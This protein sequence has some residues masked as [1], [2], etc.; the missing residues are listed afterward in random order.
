MP[1]PIGHALVGLAIAWSAESIRRV[2]LGTPALS[3]LAVTCAALATAPDLDFIYPPVHRMMSHSVTAVAAVVVLM[4]VVARRAYPHAPGLFALVSALA[5]ASHLALDWMGTDTNL[6]RGIQLWWPFSDGWFISSLEV[7]RVTRL[8]G[9]FTPGVMRMNGLAVV[10][11][12]LIIA[13]IVWG[14]WLLRSRS[15]APRDAS[16][17]ISSRA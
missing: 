8:R 11:E 3:T 14:A 6:A 1:T 13:P 2:P 9:F 15:I 7:F 10:Q 5:Y 16:P 4:A 12:L 17:L